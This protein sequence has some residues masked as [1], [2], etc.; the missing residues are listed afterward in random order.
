MK[1][2][3]YI[4]DKD[5][6]K[7]PETKGSDLEIGDEKLHFWTWKFYAGN[8]GMLLPRW[9][10]GSVSP[11][12]VL[13]AKFQNKGVPR[14]GIPFPHKRQTSRLRSAFQTSPNSD[15][16]IETFNKD[17][18]NEPLPCAGQGEERGQTLALNRAHADAESTISFALN[19]ELGLCKVSFW[20]DS[21]GSSTCRIRNRSDVFT[22]CPEKHMPS[23]WAFP[24]VQW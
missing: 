18:C 11:N 7:S 19:T 2:A 22:V 3:C 17:P 5:I 9:A 6:H 8:S 16:I 14:R 20:P 1:E 24:P 13:N 21:R 4:D 10:L 12:F 23:Q 15:L